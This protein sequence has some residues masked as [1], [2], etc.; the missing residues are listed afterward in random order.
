MALDGFRFEISLRC[1]RALLELTDE[2][3]ELQKPFP[4]ALALAERQLASG[5][6]PLLVREQVFNLLALALDREPM[7]I[8]ARA[9]ATDDA[10]VRG[11]AL[12][13]LETVL[14]ENLFSAFRPL[15]DTAGPV[16]VRPRPAADVR[17]ELIRAGATITV[18]LSELR[19]RLDATVSEET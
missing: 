14:P 3:P 19:S 12:E 11:T 5:G 10:Y 17:A 4:E 6:E 18:N 15:L 2:H 1:G 13:Y 9:F 8:A 16:P 7:R